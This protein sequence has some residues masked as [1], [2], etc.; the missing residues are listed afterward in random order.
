MTSSPTDPVSSTLLHLADGLR[1]AADQIGLPRLGAQVVQETTRRLTESRL[2]VLVLGEIK[3]GKSTLINA[4][5]GEA[6]LPT[7]VTPT[8]GAVVQL[9]RGAITERR[10][11]GPAGSEV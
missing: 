9:V 10:L 5:L 11:H 7:G 2:R 3:Q 1:L 4:L 6:L 8:T